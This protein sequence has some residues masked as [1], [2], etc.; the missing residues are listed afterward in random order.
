MGERCYRS[1]GSIRSNRGRAAVVNGQAGGMVKL[2]P[3]DNDRYHLL[4]GGIDLD[5][6]AQRKV[7]YRATCAACRRLDSSGGCATE[8]GN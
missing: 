5:V 8:I 7:G 2:E 3:V 4:S 1:T 6:R